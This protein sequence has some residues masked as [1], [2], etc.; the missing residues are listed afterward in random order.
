[1]TDQERRGWLIV[2]SLFTTLLFAFGGGYNTVPVFLPA[3]IKSFGW[4]RAQASMLPSI[5]AIASGLSAPLVGRLLDRVEARVVMTGGVAV[6]ALAFFCASR[7]NSFLPMLLTYVLLGVG[8]SAGTLAPASFVVAN[9]F[10]DRRRGIALGILMTGTTVGAMLMTQVASRAIAHS[11][12]R[13]AYVL[14]GAP[15]LLLAIP[16]ILATVRSRP[17]R[18]VKLTVAQAGDLLEGCEIAAALRTRSF[19]MI[20]YIYFA[21]FFGATGTIFHLIAAL[22]D[23]GYNAQSSAWVLTACFGFASLGKISLGL[24]ADRTSGRTAMAVNF[25]GQ[26]IGVLAAQYLVHIPFLL[27]FVISF[28]LTQGA[29]IALAPVMIVES[30]GLK[31]YGSLLGMV[32]IAG[33]VG[34]ALGPVTM[35]RIHDV[36]S[37]YSGAYDLF[38]VTNILAI[39]AAVS[40]RGY[41]AAQPGAAGIAATA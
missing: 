22:L 2:G 38:L 18:A 15:M 5:L 19:W 3:L 12:W 20:T 31:R 26:A 21:Y 24:L 25:C 16:A 36:S 14:L 32:S 28:G 34:A 17:P 9:W 8:I 23:F 29:P 39:L 30:L 13:A 10:G 40:C 27:V 4:S 11:G 6:A 35:G 41:K 33:T 7:M 37:S 1:M